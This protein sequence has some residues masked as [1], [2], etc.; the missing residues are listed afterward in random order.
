MVLVPHL[1]RCGFDDVVVVVTALSCT[2][3]KRANA[4]AFERHRKANVHA[5]VRG[6]GRRDDGAGSVN[7][8]DII[9]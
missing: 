2:V 3:C 1:A 8:D 7:A 5:F 6:Q 9:C 4:R